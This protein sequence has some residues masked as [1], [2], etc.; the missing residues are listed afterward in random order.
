MATQSVRPRKARH[1]IVFSAATG[2]PFAVAQTGTSGNQPVNSA[3][4]IA[5]SSASGLFA[6]IA[7]WA[8]SANAASQAFSFNV[9]G[10]SNA[11]N[12]E[13]DVYVRFNNFSLTGSGVAAGLYLTT[14]NGL[15]VTPA[16]WPSLARSYA[17]GYEIRAGSL[18]GLQAITA[19]FPG[20]AER[21]ANISFRAVS[22][23]AYTITIIVFF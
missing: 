17:S 14:S 3:V 6:G 20:L 21:T 5:L 13:R 12:G 22:G 10:T 15:G 9:A 18:Y 23:G 8:N 7:N 16:V 1:R 11:I 2:T 4:P 19:P